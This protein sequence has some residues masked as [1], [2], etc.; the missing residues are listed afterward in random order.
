MNMCYFIRKAKDV[1]YSLKGRSNN[2]WCWSIFYDALLF[3]C[4]FWVKK[5]IPQYSGCGFI[6]IMPHFSLLNFISYVYFIAYLSIFSKYT[7]GKLN[8]YEYFCAWSTYYASNNTYSLG[9]SRINVRRFPILLCLANSL[10]DQRYK[11][12]VF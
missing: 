3:R 5:S 7:N 8:H 11:N 12:L 2:W 10:W 1:L 9:Y 4:S 6:F